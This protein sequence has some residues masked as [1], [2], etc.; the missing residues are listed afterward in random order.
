MTSAEKQ[1]LLLAVNK[2]KR[3]VASTP[4]ASSSQKQT[5]STFHALSSQPTIN[6]IDLYITKCVEDP[7]I[8]TLMGGT[9][10]GKSYSVFELCKKNRVELT[11]FDPCDVVTISSL[12]I[13]SRIAVGNKKR[14][15]LIDALDGF[16]ET[17]QGIIVDFLANVWKSSL[18]STIVVTLSSWKET[19][20]HPLK[21]VAKRL[22]IQPPTT[23]ALVAF[24]REK[25]YKHTPDQLQKHASESC[26]DVRVFLT[27]L[28]QRGGSFVDGTKNAFEVATLVLNP[29]KGFETVDEELV[30]LDQSF[31]VNRLVLENAPNAV[32]DVDELSFILEN[33]C[34]V[35]NGNIAE[36][37]ITALSTRILKKTERLVRINM[38]KKLQPRS[39]EMTTTMF[40]ELS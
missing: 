35:R 27:R 6:E 1:R 25:E 23:D 2:K 3:V 11:V 37:T 9:G 10:V 38:Y 21:K 12:K 33:L 40:K 5:I 7:K 39:S 36:N 15:L 18:Y 31:F 24:A 19:R 4:A 22:E 20:L 34:L 13:A 28:E 30:K 26:G 14:V 32:S 17:Q 29:S 16:L 8:V